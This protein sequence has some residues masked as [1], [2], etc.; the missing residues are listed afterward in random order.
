MDIQRF[1]NSDICY[2]QTD[3]VSLK[4]VAFVQ[5]KGLVPDSRVSIDEMIAAAHELSRQ[6]V[7]FKYNKLKGIGCAQIDT[8]ICINYYGTMFTLTQD[9]SLQAGRERYE[10]IMRDTRRQK[11]G[12]KLV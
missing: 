2:K 1:E 12:M 9:M 5:P 6:L 11:I 8:S 7:D 10:Q 3:P 4:T